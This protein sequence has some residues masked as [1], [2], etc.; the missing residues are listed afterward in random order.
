MGDVLVASEGLDGSLPSGSGRL[1][2]HWEGLTRFVDDVR[3]P[4]DHNASERAQRGPAL[5]RQNY[6]GA[7][8]LWG[9]HF[10]AAM[11]SLLATLPL[12]GLNPRVWRSWSLSACP[13]GEA[14]ADIASYLPWNLTQ[15]R[16]SALSLPAPSSPS[17]SSPT[18]DS[19]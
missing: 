7:C 13:N 12:H 19:S 15:A 9:G 14:P 4:L 5:G 2:N 17:P 6:W 18:S 16:R 10:A 11:F 8:S 3:V 1:L